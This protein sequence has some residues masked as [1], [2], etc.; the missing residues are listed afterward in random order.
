MFSI[1]GEEKRK[2]LLKKD[3]NIHASFSIPNSTSCSSILGNNTASNISKLS[4]ISRAASASDI[5]RTTRAI[6]CL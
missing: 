5:L 1:F 6:I 4:K 3:Y 2:I